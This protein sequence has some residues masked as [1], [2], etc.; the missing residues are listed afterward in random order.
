M[1]RLPGVRKATVSLEK[2]EAEVEFK[3][4]AVTVE[5]MIEAI[6]QAGYSAKLLEAGGQ[7]R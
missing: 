6:K 1:E 3:E 7:G 4:G 5:Q 2:G